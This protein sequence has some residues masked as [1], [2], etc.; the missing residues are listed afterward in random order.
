[1]TIECQGGLFQR[2]GSYSTSHND[3]WSLGVILVNLVC[4][5]NPWKQAC[6]S[7]ETFR[8]YLGNPDFLRSILPISQHTNSILKRVFALNPAGRIGLAELREEILRVDKFAMSEEELKGATKATKEAARAFAASSGLA[9]IEAEAEAAKAAQRNIAEDAIEEEVAEPRVAL[10]ASPEIQIVPSSFIDSKLASI[11]AH[12]PNDQR[13]DSDLVGS[14]TPTQ[15]SQNRAT[16]SSSSSQLRSPE[17]QGRRAPPTP[18][19]TPRRYARPTVLFP[20]SPG[21]TSH[22]HS[23]SSAKLSSGFS[24]GSNNSM[25]PCGSE[26]SSM[27]SDDSFGGG[28][29][30]M[31]ES[32]VGFTTPPSASRYHS[33]SHS[34]SG[35][36]SVERDGYGSVPPT[37]V[38]PNF[39]HQSSI[40]RRSTRPGVISSTFRPS[41]PSTPISSPTATATLSGTRSSTRLST[42][43]P[44]RALARRRH[45]SF[46][47]SEDGGTSS[48][49]SNSSIFS[50]PPTPLDNCFP[51]NVQRPPLHQSSSSSVYLAPP[52]HASK[53]KVNPGYNHGRE[54]EELAIDRFLVDQVRIVSNSEEEGDGGIMRNK[55]DHD[56]DIEMADAN[57]EGGVSQ[58]YTAYYPLF[59]DWGNSQ[60]STSDGAT[61]TASVTPK[62]S[63][64]FGSGLTPPVQQNQRITRG[65]KNRT[66]SMFDLA[67]SHGVAR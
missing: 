51:S 62:S 40:P 56:P 49:T 6:P 58:S 3:V 46:D 20:N 37:P 43:R 60:Y 5:R 7:D 42:G 29:E 44:T 16:S 25:S 57:E 32:M 33:H 67:S 31:N 14:V 66:R 55:T 1:M 2:L 26:A 52:S 41:L 4:G 10:E 23:V 30:I 38:S 54:H 53:S 35:D 12:L 17:P 36:G 64:S 27:T 50:G 22:A 13:S 24:S 61:T 28:S 47:S 48:S 19:Q 8:A 59:A 65:A 21:S 9:I 63:T 15:H 34:G 45:P 18:P 11:P 39:S